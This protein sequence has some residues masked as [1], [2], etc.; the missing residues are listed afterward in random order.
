MGYEKQL[1]SVIFTVNLNLRVIQ[2]D[3]PK[4]KPSINTLL[5][6]ERSELS[7]RNN[8]FF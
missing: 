5:R 8:P 6:S 2:T 3:K 1:F 4:L 7:T